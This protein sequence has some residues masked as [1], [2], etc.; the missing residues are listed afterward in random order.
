[1]PYEY[2]PIV[3]LVLGGL[4]LTVGALTGPETKHE[5]FQSPDMQKQTK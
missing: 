4:C 1:M 2:T 5:D 3:L